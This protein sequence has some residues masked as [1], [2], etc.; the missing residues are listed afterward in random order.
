MAVADRVQAIHTYD[1]LVANPILTLQLNDLVVNALPVANDATVHGL[2]FAVRGNSMVI[3]ES[4][5]MACAIV[6]GPPDCGIQ[7]QMVVSPMR[8]SALPPG[9]A[10]GNRHQPTGLLNAAA[11]GASL[12]VTELQTGCTV[13][14]ADW[15]GGQYSMVHL[16]PSQVGQFNRLGQFI[17]NSGDSP[18]AAYQNAWLKQEMTTV[19][20][21][22]GAAPQ[23][24]IMIQSMWE[25]ARGN[26]TQ[27]IGVRQGTQ[28]R[29]FRQRQIPPAHRAV[30]QLQW[31][32]WSS[33]M[34]YLSY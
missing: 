7:K 20:Q 9:A 6:G 18:S 26:D 14:V 10:A 2:W 24:Y 5:T 34:P 32:S 27:V 29:F 1:A 11:A 23:S 3:D 21:N 30:E 31:T 12:W 13:L 19:M 16:Q 25:S 22:T 4:D 28:F 15:G 33:Y 17:L 8:G